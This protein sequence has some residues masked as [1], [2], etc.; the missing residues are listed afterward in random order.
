MINANGINA[1]VSYF[2]Y[3]GFLGMSGWDNSDIDALSNG[4]KTPFVTILTCGTGCFTGDSRSERFVR[5]GTATL[6]KGAIGCVGTATSG[7]HTVYNNCVSVGIYHGIFS[8]KIYYAGAALQ[9]GRLNLFQTLPT[10]TNNFEK[11]FSRWN[12]LIG[13]PVT[14]LWTGNPQDFSLR[15]LWAASIMTYM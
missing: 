1:G 5:V 9:R 2:N 13:D 12:N 8:D 10:I 3:R 15:F 6:P 14:K 7:T 11:V 4:S